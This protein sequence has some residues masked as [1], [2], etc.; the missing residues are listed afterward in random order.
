MNKVLV[1]VAAVVMGVGMSACSAP[2][3]PVESPVMVHD[4]PK[5]DASEHVAEAERLSAEAEMRRLAD[6]EAQRLAQEE[7]NRAKAA[8][9]GV[10]EFAEHDLNNAQSILAERSIY[11]DLDSSQ[12]REDS[13]AV[14]EAHSTFLRKFPNYKVL[15]QGNTDARGSR[16]YNLALGQ[17]RAESVK[18]MMRVLGV[19]DGQMEAVSLGKE[20][21]RAKGNSE[22]AHAQNRRVDLNYLKP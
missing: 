12:V 17:R 21:L 3:P 18:T 11:F 13:K 16:E 2:K 22:A 5:M 10:T 14:V 4:A 1:W 20:K 7:E 15:I 8:L 6:L 9:E 19:N